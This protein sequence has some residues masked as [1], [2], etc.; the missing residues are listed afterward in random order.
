MRSS[1][2]AEAGGLGVARGAEDLLCDACGTQRGPVRITPRV[3]V[4]S[5]ARRRSALPRLQ[6]SI[7]A[8]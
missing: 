2:Y 7:S 5:R 1:G 3:L 8:D 6:R 4:A